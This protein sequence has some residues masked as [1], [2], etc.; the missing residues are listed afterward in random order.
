MATKP[1][2]QPSQEND[3]EKWSEIISRM[4]INNPSGL[5]IDDGATPMGVDWREMNRRLLGMLMDLAPNREAQ[6]ILA[7]W[8]RDSIKAGMAEHEITKELINA[9]ADGFN[10]GNWVWYFR[11]PESQ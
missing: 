11:K 3:L 9:L 10:H 7:D 6:I 8:S 4:S 5:L 1:G 2:K